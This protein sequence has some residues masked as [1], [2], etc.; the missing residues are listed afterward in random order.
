MTPSHPTR[1]LIALGLATGLTL[2]LAH[3]ALAQTT[4]GSGV[5]PATILQNVVNLLNN[6]II[7]LLA[8]LAVVVIGIAWM[9]GHMDLRRA[10]VVVIGII[11][12]FGA[13][14]IVNTF[15]GSSGS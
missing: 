4:T 1:R 10:G 7:R 5:D 15:T 9:F 12:V 13:A 3:P 11:L 8:V 14:T 2:A 6:N